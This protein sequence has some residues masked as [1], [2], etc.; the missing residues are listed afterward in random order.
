MSDVLDLPIPGQKTIDGREEQHQ[1]PP[2]DELQ[3]AGPKQLGLFKAGGKEP[4][5]ASITLTG[6]KVG[7]AHGT[8]FSKGDTVQFLVT[9]TVTFVGQQ[10]KTD[11]NTG[12]VMSCEQQHKARITDITLHGIDL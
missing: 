8:A 2:L 4:T 9:A 12:I 7:L 11:G 10:D 5:S 3:V 6:G 1:P